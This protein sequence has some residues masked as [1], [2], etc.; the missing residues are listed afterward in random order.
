MKQRLGIAR[1]IS[2]KP[3]I[4][5]LDEPINGLDPIGIK[6]L[7]DLFKIL[8]REYGMTLLISSHILAEMEQ[9]SDTIGMIQN[10]RLIKEVSMM[11]ING[12]QTAYIE[13]KVLDTKKKQC[14]F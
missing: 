7:R 12:E 11:D 1:A 5:I 10:G 4:L 2:T 14:S 6:E 9:M 3:E 8:S 13:V